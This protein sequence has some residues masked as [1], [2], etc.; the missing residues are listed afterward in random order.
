[1]ASCRDIGV[2]KVIHF[3]QREIT[4]RKKRGNN[5]PET[6]HCSVCGKAIRVENF[7][8]QMAKL[9]RHYKKHHPKKFKESIK[10]GVKKRKER[11]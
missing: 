1:M 10:R 11:K 7:A 4:K 9:R 8:D 6:I 5:M 2:P 3:I